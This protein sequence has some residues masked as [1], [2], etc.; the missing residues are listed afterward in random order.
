MMNKI[1]Y[2]WGALRLSMGWIFL[3]AFLDKILG[4]GFSTEA[5]KAWITGGSPTTGFL[6]FATKGP[7]EEFFKE[8]FG[9][10]PNQRRNPRRPE[11]AAGSGVIISDDGYIVTNNHVIDNAERI[12][13][14]LDDNRTYEA[15]L[16]G[17]DPTTDLA[18][19]KI[20]HNYETLY[21]YLVNDVC[22]KFVVSKPYSCN[23][24]ATDIMAYNSNL[25]SIAKLKW[26][27]KDFKK[28]Y[29][30][31]LD[32]KEY[33]VSIVLNYDETTHQEGDLT[34]FN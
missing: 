24:L 28:V 32:K 16:I 5:G 23:C 22:V 18:L 17:I 19:I 10:S 20:N 31:T 7:F 13:V 15:K 21:F 4:L 1:N 33:T 9:E 30:T 27:S 25:T 12:E 14:T 6:T 26:V 34:L 2:L 11:M 29:Q 3:W 8:Y